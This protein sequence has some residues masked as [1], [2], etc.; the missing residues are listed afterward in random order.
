[1]FL[2][3]IDSIGVHSFIPILMSFVRFY[4]VYFAFTNSMHDL[5]VLVCLIYPLFLECDSFLF[6]CDPL[7]YHIVYIGTLPYSC[8]F[9]LENGPGCTVRK[10][11]NKKICYEM[12]V[13][14]CLQICRK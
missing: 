13:I 4:V 10:L 1:M 2:D 5:F 12:D 14:H 6:I 3:F 11:N 8:H 9:I 7:F